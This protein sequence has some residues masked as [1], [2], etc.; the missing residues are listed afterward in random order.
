[1]LIRIPVGNGPKTQ[2]LAVAVNLTTRNNFVPIVET[3]AEFQSSDTE[4]NVCTAS[5]A[6]YRYQV[7]MGTTC[8][9]ELREDVVPVRPAPA[10]VLNTGYFSACDI[11]F[12]AQSSR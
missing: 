11:P 8:T 12:G 1:M 2:S 5:W 4:E 6:Q 3:K 9:G 10:L 7:L